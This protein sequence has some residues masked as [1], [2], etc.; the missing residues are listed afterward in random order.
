MWFNICIRKIV[1]IIVVMIMNFSSG[2][3]CSFLFVDWYMIILV[4]MEVIV[5]ENC[6]RD[7][8][9]FMQVFLFCGVGMVEVSVEVEI[10]WE[11]ILMK[12]RMFSIMISQ[13]GVSLSF[14]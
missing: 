8:L 5:L 13:K 9:I 12:S 7:E 10:I 4:I 3:F 11:E 1:M 2:Q 6:C 14:V